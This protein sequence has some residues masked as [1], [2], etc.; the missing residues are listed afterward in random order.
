M[1]IYVHVYKYNN[2]CREEEKSRKEGREK[3]E[4]DGEESTIKKCTQ[5]TKLHTF[6][7]IV[8]LTL[9]ASL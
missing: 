5:K 4:Q 6:D 9:S 7:V 8:L 3:K 1:H 2:S